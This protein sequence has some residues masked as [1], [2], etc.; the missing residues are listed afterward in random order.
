MA[1]KILTLKE[2]QVTIGRCM[3]Y[4]EVYEYIT[5]KAVTDYHCDNSD[6]FIAKGTECA[7]IMVLTHKDHPN[8][9]HQ[10]NMLKNYV[11]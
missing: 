5:G 8:Y 9:E 2:L 6:E 3:K 7:A 10:K 11:K 4:G 1:I